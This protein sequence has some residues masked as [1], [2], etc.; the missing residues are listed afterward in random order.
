MA[1]GGNICQGLAL[2]GESRVGEVVGGIG[3]LAHDRAGGRGGDGLGDTDGL[4]LG[5]ICA[6]AGA[7]RR[8]LRMGGV[9]D[10]GRRVPVMAQG[11]HVSHR[12]GLRGKGGVDKRLGGV[13]GLAHLRAG[14][15]RGFCACRGRDFGLNVVMLRVAGAGAGARHRGVIFIPIIGDA[16]VV[17]LQ[18][19]LAA[20]GRVLLD[21]RKAVLC[22][23]ARPVG[24][25]ARRQTQVFDITESNVGNG[26]E[27]I[28]QGQAGQAGAIA[29]SVG[30]DRSH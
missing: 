26:I 28:R 9:P 29:E 19:L 13:G 18:Q 2:H 21:L 14:G 3:G 16:P 12:H 24:A 23:P 6:L 5:M 20:H 22:G 27:G 30:T 8:H 4:G 25:A 15:G 7:C 17:G 10:V 1:Q 11:R